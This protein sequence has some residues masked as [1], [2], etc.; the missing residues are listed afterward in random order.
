M[1]CFI[2]LSFLHIA[3][4]LNMSVLFFFCLLVVFSLVDLH[5]PGG[6]DDNE[7]MADHVVR[8][9]PETEDAF[10]GGAEPE[11]CGSERLCF[12]FACGAQFE[13]PTDFGHCTHCLG[14][15]TDVA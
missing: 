2:F 12:C 1:L 14:H 15:G 9:L 13:S 10:F 5:A 8:P 6:E 7:M 3:D 11:E 4:L